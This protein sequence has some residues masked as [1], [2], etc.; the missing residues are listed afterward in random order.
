MLRSVGYFKRAVQVDP[1]YALAYAGLAEAY[2][3]MSG[4]GFVAPRKIMPKAKRAVIRA[5]E[6]DNQLTEAQTSLGLVLSNFDWNWQEGE[7]AYRRA[8]EFSPDNAA[9]H[10]YY[11][12]LL[13]K[14][15]RLDQ[16]VAEIKKAFEI[17]PISLHIHLARAKISY[18]A[19]RYDVA[20]EH[21][22]EML[23]LDRSFGPANGL[24][25]MVYLEQRYYERA[26]SQFKRMIPF[27]GR[28]Y[29]SA[30]KKGAKGTSGVW[31]SDPEAIGVLG[32]A[33]GQT[34]NRKKAVEMLKRL[35]ELEKKSL[36][37]TLY[38]RDSSH[39]PER[40]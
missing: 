36:C 8:I 12:I 32:F 13:A 3:M 27:S 11:S 23:E 16:A 26:I 14:T 6:S 37:R 25:A 31:D 39:W 29:Q 17:D 19:K 18:F 34:G 30:N 35:E 1:R 9:A 38:H 24:I 2:I 10:H 7:K 4:F 20:A 5:L 33:Y 21:C 15:G 22:K 28:D 40:L